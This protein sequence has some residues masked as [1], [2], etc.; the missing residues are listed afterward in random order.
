MAS[1]A[2]SVD[3]EKT[4]EEII[5]KTKDSFKIFYPIYWSGLKTLKDAIALLIKENFASEN[6]YV[7]ALL[8][9]ANRSVQHLESMRILTERGLYGDAFVLSRSLMSDVAMIQYLRYKPEFVEDFLKETRESYQDKKSGFST[10]FNETAIHKVLTD[11]GVP[12]FRNSFEVLSKT[13]HASAFGAQLYGSRGGKGDQYHLKYGPGFETEKALA[14]FAITSAGHF[15]L[16]DNILAYRCQQDPTPEWLK[17]LSETNALEGRVEIFSQ[18]TVAA[19]NSF[20][21][22]KRGG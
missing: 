15:D 20:I 9:L 21:G 1:N 17:V 12:P 14:V 13:V 10:K 2:G 3:F 6:K 4:E 22:K 8:V 19:M 11:A 16:L 18:S 5:G 7:T